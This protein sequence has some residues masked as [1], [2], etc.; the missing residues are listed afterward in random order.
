MSPQKAHTNLA[1]FQTADWIRR[2]ISNMF[3]TGCRTTIIKSALE[4]AHYSANYKAVPLTI[5]L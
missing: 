4:Y 2:Q 3:D 5:S 1:D